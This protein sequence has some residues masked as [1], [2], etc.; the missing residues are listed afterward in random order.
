MP[1]E[2]DCDC[3]DQSHEGQCPDHD[4]PHRP[5]GERSRGRGACGGCSSGHSATGNGIA[6]DHAAGT[7]PRCAAFAYR[8][9]QR[10]SVQIS[11]EAVV[12]DSWE[13]QDSLETHAFPFVVTI[14]RNPE[15]LKSTGIM[16]NGEKGALALQCAHALPPIPA[17]T[18]GS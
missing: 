1:V 4:D 17:G 9:A 7:Y 16:R 6:I 18:G 12:C 3:G 15:A 11:R 13:A 2:Q 10:T 14:M 5:A 8:P